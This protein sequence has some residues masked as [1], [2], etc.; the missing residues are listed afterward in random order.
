MRFWKFLFHRHSTGNLMCTKKSE[1]FIKHD[2]LLTRLLSLNCEAQTCEVRWIWGR[3]K[4]WREIFT[5]RSVILRRCIRS[6]RT[7]W[8][9]TWRHLD[10]W[11]RRP[12]TQSSLSRKIEHLCVEEYR[13][14]RVLVLIYFSKSPKSFNV[15]HSM[16]SRHWRWRH[17]I[18]PKHR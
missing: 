1:L 12:K 13:C 4:G 10:P 11:N 14:K 3:S 15:T 18:P 16:T 2:D 8:P 17:Y 9:W 5:C 6:S 7:F